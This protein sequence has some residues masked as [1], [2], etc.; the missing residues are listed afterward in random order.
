MATQGRGFPSSTPDTDSVQGFRLT[1]SCTW[2]W[3]WYVQP[4]ST[5]NPMCLPVARRPRVC[6]SLRRAE[7]VATRARAFEAMRKS[8]HA[9]R[10][11]SRSIL[12]VSGAT[13]IRGSKLAGVAAS[14]AV[15]CA[16][17]DSFASRSVSATCLLA[18]GAEHRGVQ[19]CVPCPTWSVQNTRA[20]DKAQ[21]ADSSWKFESARQAAASRSSAASPKVELCGRTLNAAIRLSSASESQVAKSGVDRMGVCDPGANRISSRTNSVAEVPLD[22]RRRGGATHE[23]SVAC[24]RCMGTRGR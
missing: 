20:F 1:R 23:S 24:N 6:L 22:R 2:G 5:T 17:T 19:W 8:I 4:L 11:A 14:L 9:L 15:A 12:H 7:R 3:M 16:A 13:A 21:A 10:V 18:S